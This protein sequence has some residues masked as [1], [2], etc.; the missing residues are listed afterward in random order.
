MNSLM[1][2]DHRL[3]LLQFT[4]IGAGANGSHF[5]RSLCQDLRTHMDR[6]GF[7]K[8]PTFK[9]SNIMLVDGDVCELKNLGNQIFDRDD[10][11]E[12]KVIALA[13]RYGDHVRL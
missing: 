13:E 8:A 6:P 3:P 9:L 2:K 7:D 10:V 11:G 5:F 12:K 1:Y 4:I